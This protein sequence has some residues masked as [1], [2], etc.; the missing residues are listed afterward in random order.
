MSTGY[1]N[2][3]AALGNQG[4]L[5][6]VN[7]FT[8]MV[9]VKGYHGKGSE[10]TIEGAIELSKTYCIK[11]STGL[12]IIVTG[13]HLAKVQT[14][15]GRSTIPFEAIIE[16]HKDYDKL[17]NLTILDR[18]VNLEDVLPCTEEDK[19]NLKAN[20]SDKAHQSEYDFWLRFLQSPLNKF[21]V[22]V[23]TDAQAAMTGNI[24]IEFEQNTHSSWKMD[25][26]A[27]A[28]PSGMMI[29][30]SEIWAYMISPEVFILLHPN[31]LM[32]YYERRNASPIR[33]VAGGNKTDNDDNPRTKGILI[34]IHYLLELD[35]ELNKENKFSSTPIPMESTMVSMF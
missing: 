30:K 5:F 28:K 21:R 34:P 14:A 9:Q 25:W 23:K 3:D 35:L 16:A 13:M 8:T 4:E 27:H 2:F 29:S 12:S 6:A 19:Q 15:L 18:K 33:V 31:K 1:F 7:C 11:R 17:L 22:E 20:H 26:D 24:F 10:V 32:E